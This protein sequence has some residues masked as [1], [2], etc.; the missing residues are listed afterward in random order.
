MLPELLITVAS[1]R[2]DTFELEVSP[3]LGCWS[4]YCCDPLTVF[5][6]A[7]ENGYLVIARSLQSMII[8]SLESKGLAV[9]VHRQYGYSSEDE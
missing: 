1:S 7:F 6:Y 9:L 3:V 2:S 8:T 4:T 5:F